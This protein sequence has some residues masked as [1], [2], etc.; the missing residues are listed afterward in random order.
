MNEEIGGAT[1]DIVG[2]DWEVS[3]CIPEETYLGNVAIEIDSGLWSWCFGYCPQSYRY[4]SLQ[5]TWNSVI[6]TTWNTSSYLNI[7]NWVKVADCG[8]TIFLDETHAQWDAQ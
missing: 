1:V 5:S 3:F 4:C 6:D 7:D 2:A 8:L